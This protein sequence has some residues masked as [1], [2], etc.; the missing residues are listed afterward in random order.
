[1]L[2]IGTALVLFAV[3]IALQLPA[4]RGARAVLGRRSHDRRHAHRVAKSAASRRERL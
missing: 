3:A 1:M 4:E 2:R